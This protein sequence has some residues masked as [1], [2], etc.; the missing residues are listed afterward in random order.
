MSEHSH[1]MQLKER[2]LE[3]IIAAGKILNEEG[4]QYLTTK[5]LAEK[6]GVAEGTLYRHFKSKDDI[7]QKMLEFV[8]KDIQ[9]RL[10]VLEESD[11]NEIDKI[12]SFFQSQTQFIL[13]H[14]YL[15]K[16]I[17]SE[18]I[19]IAQSQSMHHI[20]IM[21]M[22]KKTLESMLSKGQ[23]NKTVRKDISSEILAHIIMSSF[24]LL[25]MKWMLMNQAFDV[26]KESKKLSVAFKKMITYID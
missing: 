3:I 13:A 21:L 18:A 6:L 5:N 26:K 7:L 11:A 2:Q 8:E 25:L 23:K 4:I 19:T 20:K 10:L 12:T 1:T 24:R 15:L 14:P 16:I 9:R 22:I 17:F